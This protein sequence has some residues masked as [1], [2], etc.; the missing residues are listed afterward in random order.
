MIAIVWNY[1]GL[2]H[3]ATIRALRELCNSHRPN[4]VFLSETKI[5]NPPQ[6]HRI[7]HNLN[8]DNVHMVPANGSSGGLALFWKQDLDVQIVGDSQNLITFMVLNDLIAQPWCFTGVYGPP[9]PVLK[10]SFWEELRCIGDT[11]NGP[12]CVL[13]D[14]NA[15]LEQREK[16]GGRPFPLEV[17]SPFAE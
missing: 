9:I 6:I 11:V 7:A 5:C 8:F 4:L 16:L 14:F 12:W 17:V 10:P 1:R 2:C 15:I 3:T 13:G